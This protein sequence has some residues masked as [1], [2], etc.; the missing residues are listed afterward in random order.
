MGLITESDQTVQACTAA[1]VGYR[2]LLWM[3]QVFEMG[4][5]IKGKNLLLEEQILYFK[6]RPLLRREAKIELLP[7]QVYS[8]TNYYIYIIIIYIYYYII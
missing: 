3:R 2:S 7:L 6:S 4:S 8:L 5:T 1:V